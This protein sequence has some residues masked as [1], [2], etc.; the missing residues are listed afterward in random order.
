MIEVCFFC[1]VCEEKTNGASARGGE[2]VGVC[3]R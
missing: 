3:R 1:G 2:D